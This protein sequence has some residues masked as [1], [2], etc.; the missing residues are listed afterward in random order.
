MAACRGAVARPTWCAGAGPGSTGHLRRL[1]TV[2]YFHENGNVD[3]KSV[4]AALAGLAQDLRLDIFRLL[5]EQGPEGLPA[6]A[7]AEKLRVANATL[8]FHLKELAHAKL[9]SARQDGR[10]VYYSANFRTM[11]GLMEY[12]TDNCCLG[13][14]CDI[15]CA[16][17]TQRKRKSS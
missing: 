7:I 4:L 13:V 11:N 3:R 8:S 10:F 5:V 2:P 1:T 14:T 12:L 6:G 17:V 16:P 15:A 9:V